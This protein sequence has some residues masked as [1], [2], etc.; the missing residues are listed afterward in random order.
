MNMQSD[1]KKRELLKNPT[2]IEEIQEKKI[3]DR[4]WTI[5]TCLLRECNPNY[6]CLKITSCRW[7]SPPRMHSFTAT[8]HFKSSRSFVSLCVCCML[9]RMRLKIMWDKC[10]KVISRKTYCKKTIARRH[11]IVCNSYTYN[12]KYVTVT[13]SHIISI[14]Q[15]ISFG[16][17]SHTFLL[18]I[19]SNKSQTFQTHTHPYVHTIHTHISV[20]DLWR[21]DQV[22]LAY[23]KSATHRNLFSWAGVY[24][25]NF[26]HNK[27]SWK[28]S[29]T[30]EL[31]NTKWKC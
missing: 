24:D 12:H 11:H 30:G 28:W 19:I 2:K 23:L 29:R 1:T 15:T 7:R 5:K 17:L 22:I 8:T 20:C 27:Y 13:S 10:F 31:L 3:I 6:Q 21:R 25:E 4:N 18:K 16:N 9:C 26:L 14:L